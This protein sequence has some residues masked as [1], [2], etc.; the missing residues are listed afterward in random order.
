VDSWI[1]HPHFTV[2]DN[3]STQSFK[4]KIESALDTVLKFIGLPTPTSFYK[5]YLLVKD[6]PIDLPIDIK[7][8][9]FNAI[10]IFL[11]L[12]GDQVD[13]FLRRSGKDDTYIYTHEIRYIKNNERI[14]KK[15]QITPR[16][17]I[18]L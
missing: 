16:E 18:S 2:I 1:G 17:F 11:Q 10:E 3:Y 14:V 9:T 12:S 6:S 5:K 8:E 15:S 7:F 13:N 4:H